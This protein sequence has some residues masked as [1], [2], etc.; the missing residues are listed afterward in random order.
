MNFQVFNNEFG[1]ANLGDLLPFEL[2]DFNFDV[3][4]IFIVKNVPIGV[5][6]GGHS[7]YTTKQV[8]YCL[9]GEIEVL[10]YESKDPKKIIL[11]ENDFITVDPLVWDE[12]VFLTYDS[13]LL[14]FCNTDYNRAD[15]IEDFD[16]FLSIKN[17]IIN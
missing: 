5:K 10:L 6:R 3:K 17:N 4:R 1:L 11:K 2:K 8:L 14:S 15:Y 13:I 7:H 16:K 9:R 12:Q